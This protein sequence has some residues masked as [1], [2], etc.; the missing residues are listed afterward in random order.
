MPDALIIILQFLLWCGIAL[1]AH[2]VDSRYYLMS[3]YAAIAMVVA[4]Q[5]VSYLET[6]TPDPLWLMTSMITFC[7]GFLLALLI[8]LPFRLS[9]VMKKTDDEVD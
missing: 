9:R 6:G 2:V 5:V 8:G 4:T 3:V 7:L 1:V